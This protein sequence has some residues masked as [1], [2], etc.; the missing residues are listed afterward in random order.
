MSARQSVLNKFQSL[1]KRRSAARPSAREHS[2][3]RGDTAV[4]LYN[5]KVRSFNGR[6]IIL[7]VEQVKFGRHANRNVVFGLLNGQLFNL[8]PPCCAAR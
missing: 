2:N 3:Q 1:S 8:F 6:C 4:V 7:W 5:N